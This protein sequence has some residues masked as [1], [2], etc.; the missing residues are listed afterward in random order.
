MFLIL[1]I[2]NI[3]VKGLTCVVSGSGNVAQFCA[4]KL[5]TLG[6][7]VLTF[8]DSSGY[9]IEEKGFTLDQV[10]QIMHLKNVKRGRVSEY[11]KVQK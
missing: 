9:V 2:Q 10:K 5:L 11:T 4:E 3:D 8:S 7:V 6:A 1:I